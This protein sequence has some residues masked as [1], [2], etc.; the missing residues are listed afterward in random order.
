MGPLK[1]QAIEFSL[2]AQNNQI[3][4]NWKHNELAKFP[5]PLEGTES[6]EEALKKIAIHLNSLS[7]QLRQDLIITEGNVLFDELCGEFNAQL[8]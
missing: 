2:V 7:N 3:H 1:G 4:L 6:L 8:L 5:I